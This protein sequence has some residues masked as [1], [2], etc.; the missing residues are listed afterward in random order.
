[1]EGN[2]NLVTNFFVWWYGEAYAKFFVYLTKF[3]AYVADLFSVKIC[4][5]TLFAPWKRDQLS[6]EGLTLQDRFQVLMLNLSSRLI[7]AV[8]KIIV[9]ATFLVAAMFIIPVEL[10]LLVLWA[11]WPIVS[12]LLLYIGLK[13]L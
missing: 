8:V 6:G 2:D 4:L 5:K 7:G 10:G 13:N 1:M 9:L 11:T 3:L 12:L